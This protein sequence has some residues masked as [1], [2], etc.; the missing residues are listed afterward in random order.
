MNQV[1]II[2][3]IITKCMLEFEQALKHSIHSHSFSPKITFTILEVRLWKLISSGLTNKH[4]KINRISS[5]ISRI[6][7]FP[8]FKPITPIEHNNKTRVLLQN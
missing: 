3:N 5:V 8:D 6:N 7:K 4:N 1:N 2:D